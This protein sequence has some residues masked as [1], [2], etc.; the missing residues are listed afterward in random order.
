MWKKKLSV[1]VWIGCSTF[2]CMTTETEILGICKKG[3][4]ERERERARNDRWM[5][6]GD[7]NPGPPAAHLQQN[8]WFNQLELKARTVPEV[9]RSAT[10]AETYASTPEPVDQKPFPLLFLCRLTVV[11]QT[12]NSN[13]LPTNAPLFFRWRANGALLL[14]NC[15]CAVNEMVFSKYTDWLSEYGGGGLSV[16]AVSSNCIRFIETRETHKKCKFLRY[17][18]QKSARTLYFAYASNYMWGIEIMEYLYERLEFGPMSIFDS[19]HIDF[20]SPN[21]LIKQQVYF[22]LEIDFVCCA[23]MKQTNAV[24]YVCMYCAR[25]RTTQNPLYV[26]VFIYLI[27]IFIVMLSCTRINISKMY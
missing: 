3:I 10:R 26:N 14:F 4:P 12:P 27:S 15:L 20:F 19:L 25:A 8:E 24:M 2:W 9:V 7:E 1:I 23:T 5:I 16:A 11:H 21:W 6:D 18:M 17:K 22:N 13:S